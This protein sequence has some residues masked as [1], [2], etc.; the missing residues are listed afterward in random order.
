MSNMLFI[1]AL[2]LNLIKKENILTAYN[3]IYLHIL[4]MEGIMSMLKCFIGHIPVVN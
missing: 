1:N 3:V 2:L 4:L